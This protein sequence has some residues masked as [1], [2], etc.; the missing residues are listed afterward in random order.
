MSFTKVLSR[1]FESVNRT[2]SV[3]LVIALVLSGIVP[4]REIHF[5]RLQFTDFFSK[6]S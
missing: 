4:Y 5:V 2:T 1:T 3:G 6:L